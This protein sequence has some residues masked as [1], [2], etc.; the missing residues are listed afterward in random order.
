M[1]TEFY[2]KVIGQFVSIFR[3]MAVLCFLLMSF[4]TQA[5]YYVV[6]QDDQLL[7][8]IKKLKLKPSY[9]VLQEVIDANLSIKTQNGNLIQPLQK[10][11]FPESYT[12]E[13][14]KVARITDSGEI[15]FE[16]LPLVENSVPAEALPVPVDDIKEEKILQSGS[17][18]GGLGLTYYQL[19]AQNSTN[20]SDGK[21]VSGA[22]PTLRLNWTQPFTEH[23]KFILGLRYSHVEI[24]KSETKTLI[25]TQQSLLE[26]SLGLNYKIFK[27]RVI[28]AEQLV[29]RVITLND[30]Q[31]EKI[32][33]IMVSV[34]LEYNFIGLDYNYSLPYK[35][36]FYDI[37]AGSGFRANIFYR[38]QFDKKN[39][40]GEIFYSQHQFESSPVK[41]M[42]QQ[43][44]A[45]MGISWDFES[46][47]E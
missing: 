41:F 34:G 7:V 38:H 26:I 17:I 46:K 45:L 2:I 18:F 14:K 6:Q 36:D 1:T 39:I 10:I 9:K 30:L 11:Y 4:Q 23:L 22:S 40:F 5:A 27:A 25:D 47:T 28:Q 19:Q 8:I 29:D 35:N 12:D 3:S 21:L 20:Q 15:K 16:D 33:L 44:G 43:V 31:V 24:S 42:D 13:I 37:Q 32:P